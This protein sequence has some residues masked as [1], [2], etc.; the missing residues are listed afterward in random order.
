M[1][2]IGAV[3]DHRSREGGSI[4]YPVYSRRSRGL[5]IGI[6]LFPGHK[7]CSF[8]CPYCE[9]FP[10]ETDIVFNIEIMKTAL[11]S[12][13]REAIKNAIPIMDI[14]FSGN[15]EPTMS[16][17]FIEA[18]KAA[19]SIRSMLAGDAKLVVITNGTGLFN[20]EMFDF[21]KNASIDST[22]LN[23]WLKLDAAT[24]AWYRLLNR[25]SIPH[26]ELVDSIKKFSASNA[27]FTIQ[28]MLCKIKG[29]LPPEEESAAWIQLVTELSTLSGRCG[30]REVQI[31]GKARPAA[32]D[33]LAEA[34]PLT[35]LE[36]RA[37]LLRVSLE[38]AGITVPAA[39]Y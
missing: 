20:K 9:V 8:D 4:I 13:I 32:E 26:D 6:N 24:E 37:A 33:P 25:S 29:V 2:T 27:P 23:I 38:K 5:S 12:A 30:L 15:G 34:V 1:M 19:S 31:Y 11:C 10:F 18:V 35:I 21:L 7:E 14:C 17:Y 28:T 16:P 39:V 36:E 3:T 22:D